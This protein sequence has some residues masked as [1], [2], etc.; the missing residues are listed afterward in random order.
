MSN[1][2]DLAPMLEA[3]GRL[4]CGRVVAVAN[5]HVDVDIA[6]GGSRV[7][8]CR[9]LEG[10]PLPL[11]VGD[12]VLL[13]VQLPPSAQV[14]ERSLTDAASPSEAMDGIVVGRVRPYAAA[15]TSRPQR[16]V[17]EAEEEVVLRNRNGRIRI[18]ANGEIEIFGL[19]ITSRC[20]RLMRLLAPMIKLN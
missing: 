16:L 17:L 5:G 12:E 10:C 14:V 11:A 1:I 4:Q 2:L 7:R 15:S 18:A 13:L 20:R 8:S 6:G 9:M 19:T 3:M